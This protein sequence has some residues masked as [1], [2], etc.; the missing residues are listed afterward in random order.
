MKVT[1]MY[2]PCLQKR[3]LPLRHCGSTAIGTSLASSLFAVPCRHVSNLGT[4]LFTAADASVHKTLVNEKNHD[5]D[6]PLPSSFNGR[7]IEA[8]KL[9]LSFLQETEKTLPPFDVV[10]IKQCFLPNSRTKQLATSLSLI[11]LVLAQSENVQIRN[12]KADHGRKS[13]QTILCKMQATAR[14]Q[15]NA[16]QGKR[17]VGPKW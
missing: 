6:C 13:R 15:G 17:M 8:G 14:N 10:D 2:L 11:S 7:G 5:I 16:R 3:C 9:Q 4:I 1:W 12:S